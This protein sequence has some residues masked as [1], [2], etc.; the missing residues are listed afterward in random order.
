MP[1]WQWERGIWVGLRNE[2]REGWTK[3]GALA[4]VKRKKEGREIV[5]QAYNV[6]QTAI[7]SVAAPY[8]G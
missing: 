6:G 8:R 2:T 1:K 7:L 5:R 3:M 4:G